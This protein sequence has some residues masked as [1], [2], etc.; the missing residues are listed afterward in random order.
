MSDIMCPKC[1]NKDGAEVY[2]DP[3]IDECSRCYKERA[4]KIGWLESLV[5]EAYYEGYKTGHIER[6]AH[7]GSS[8]FMSKIRRRLNGDEDE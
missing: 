3:E 5:V 4:D 1:W 7:R 2:F 6:G 8:W